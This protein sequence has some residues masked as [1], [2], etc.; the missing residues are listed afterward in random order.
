MKRVSLQRDR[1]RVI[2]AGCGA[3]VLILLAW[4]GWHLQARSAT[5]PAGWSPGSELDSIPRLFAPGV[6]STGDDESHAEISPD[7]TTLYFLKNTPTFDTWT[8][9]RS[10]WN[11]GR[12]STPEVAPFSGRWSDADPFVTED[13]LRLYYISTRPVDGGAKEDTDLWMVER[14]SGGDW[15][16]PRHLGP[17]VNSPASEWF[18]TVTRN[19]TLYFG[20]ERP[21]GKGSADIWR[22]RLVNGVYQEPENLGEPV[23]TPAGEFEPMVSPDER[24]MVFAAA[25][26]PGSLGRFDLWI[27]YNQDGAWSKPEHLSAPMN[28]DGWDFGPRLTHDG[29]C[30]FF[31]SSR[32]TARTLDRP[33]KYEELLARLH[34]PGNGLRDIYYV[35]TSALPAAPPTPSKAPAR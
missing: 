26:R 28:S 13:G 14:S 9:V 31:T 30:L 34:A 6:I 4:T 27:S 12:W 19:G 8:I 7:G 29:R 10:R 25:G 16:S 17:A 35:S 15:G 20:S 2:P 33:L 23:N 24:F 18:P 21:G 22:S 3:A 32:A 5:G 11:A 1:R